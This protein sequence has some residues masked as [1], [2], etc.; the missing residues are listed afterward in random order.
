MKKPSVLTEGSTV[1]LIAPSSSFKPALLERAVK[2]LKSWGLKPQFDK[3]IL[4]KD[5]VF[6]G[7][8]KTRLELLKDALYDDRVDAIW[9][10]RGGYGSPR[11]MPKVLKWKAPKKPKLIIGISD[12]TALH[13]HFM[14]N[15]KWITVHGPLATRLGAP[16]AS[17]RETQTLKK[18]LFDPDFRLKVDSGLR[19]LGR[20]GRVRGP[21]TGGNLKLLEVSL[22]TD[23]E[24]DTRGKILFIEDIGEKS[25]SIDR[26]LVHLEQAGKFDQ[27][28]GVVVGDFTDCIEMSGKKNLW[29]E[30]LKRFF[31]GASFPVIAGLRAGH[32]PKTQLSFPLGAQVEIRAVGSRSSFEI[33][34]SATLAR[35][36]R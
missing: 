10:M 11:L 21:L 14:Q 4:Q 13:I 19:S 3:R 15:W 30:V 23:W 9:C 36:R 17:A 34:E 24:I 12:I 31:K 6:A 7:S 5:F 35:S 22:G 27:I 33:L 28:K 20:S 29:K 18:T 1:A 2:T 16:D 26:M 32:D 8:D 25:Y